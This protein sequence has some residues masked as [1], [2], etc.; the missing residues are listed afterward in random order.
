MKFGGCKQ[1]WAV[2]NWKLVERCEGGGVKTWN[3]GFAVGPHPCWET[4]YC[5]SAQTRGTR[6]FSK[7]TVGAHCVISSLRHPKLVQNR[8]FLLPLLW[9]SFIFSS[10]AIRT[11]KMLVQIPRIVLIAN[12][13]QKKKKRPKK[14]TWMIITFIYNACS[15]FFPAIENDCFASR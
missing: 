7:P 8:Q 11:S 5:I 4:C 14:P 15:F 13:V 9:S 6:C 3:K 1:L 10:A 12:M 2:V